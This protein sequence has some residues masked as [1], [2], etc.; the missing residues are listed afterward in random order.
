[1]P[2][3][4]A[5]ARRF[6]AGETLDAALPA[7]A[8]LLDG[9][10]AVTLDLLGEHVRDPDRAD[11]FAEAYRDLVGRLAAFRDARGA[12]DGAVGI[13][14]KLSMIGQVTDRDQ[15]EANLRALLDA[16]RAADVFVRLDMEGSDLTA[17]TLSLFESVYPD[18][19]DHVG[20]VLQAYL[21]RTDRDV[22]RMAELGARVRLCKGAYAEGPD[23]AHPDMDLI[24]WHFRRYAARLLTAGRYPAIATHDDGLITAV[25]QFAEQNGVARDAF[26]FQMLYGLRPETQR[27]LVRDGYRMRVYVPYGTE[28]V[29]YFSRRLRER[30]ENVFFVLKALARG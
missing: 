26:E 11:A 20:P 25:R 27:Q 18:Y 5:L 7:I 16:A 22:E 13:S 1:M 24:R 6:V 15:C 4:F 17:S 12:P 8:P 28:W 14:I 3:P 21:H 23:L 2:L 30:K 10:L 9:G 19:P 29:P